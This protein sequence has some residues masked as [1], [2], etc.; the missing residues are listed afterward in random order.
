MIEI[1]AISPEAQSLITLILMALILTLF[2]YA[3]LK[4]MPPSTQEVLTTRVIVRCINNDHEEQ[5]TFQKG[6]YIGKIL[7]E[8][9]PKCSST[10]YIHR[11]YAENLFEG[12]KQK[13]T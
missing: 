12:E 4:S 6:L 3:I 2:Y 5:R 11:I 1:M 7:D 8:K 13:K 9:C 10:L